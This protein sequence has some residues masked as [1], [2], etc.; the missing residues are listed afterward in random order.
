MSASERAD[1]KRWS[2]L[3]HPAPRPRQTDLAGLADEKTDYDAARMPG[4]LPV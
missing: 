2:T 4:L 3:V 1:E